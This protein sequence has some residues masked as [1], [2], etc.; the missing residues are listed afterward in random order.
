VKKHKSLNL[1]SS[2]YHNYKVSCT[3]FL[4][5]ISAALGILGNEFGMIYL[6][7]SFLPVLVW[8]ILQTNENKNT[9]L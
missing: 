7:F 4:L 5:G 2:N 8:G 6:V 1:I 9:D 3:M